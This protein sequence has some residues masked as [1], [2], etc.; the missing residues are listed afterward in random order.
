[1]IPCI[2]AP[3]DTVRLTR[4]R[5]THSSHPARVPRLHNICEL[6]FLVIHC[7]PK[8]VSSFHWIL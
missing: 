3:K 5:L 6:D 8:D 1:M 2:L 4:T 7:F